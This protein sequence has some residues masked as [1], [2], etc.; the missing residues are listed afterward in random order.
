MKEKYLFLLMFCSLTMIAQ[1]R[2]GYSNNL[3]KI[4]FEVSQKMIAVE[5]N[6]LQKMKS[7]EKIIIKGRNFKII[8]S[9]ETEYASKISEIRKGGIKTE[10][11]LIYSNGAKQICRGEIIIK[12][13]SADQLSRILK[14]IEYSATKNEYVKN[15]YKV[16]IKNYDTFKIF[17]LVSSLANDERIDFVEPNFISLESFQTIDPLYA[18]QWSISNNG[19]LGGTIDADMDVEEA[20]AYSNGDGVKVAVLDIGVDLTHPDLQANLLPGF[21]A[22]YNAAGGG[23]VYNGQISAHGTACAG[24]IGAVSNNIGTVGVAYNSKIIPVR[25]S[26]A[27]NIDADDAALGINWASTFGEADILSCS[28][29]LSSPSN[30]LTN[31]INYAVSN[32]RN[33]KGC[34]V[35]FATGNGNGEV[36]YP[37]SLPNV[38]AVGATSQCDQRKSPA[39]CDG[40]NNWGSNYGTNLDIVAPGVKIATTDIQGYFGFDT[41]GDYMSTFNGTSSACPNAAGVMALILSL[42]PNLTSAQA[43]Q[44][45]ESSTDKITSYS[46]T[47]NVSGQLNGTWNNEVGYG[48]INALKAMKVLSPYELYGGN[49]VCN[50]P[51]QT[52]VG[53]TP[54]PPAGSTITWTTSSNLIVSSTLPPSTSNTPQ[55]LVQGNLAQGVYQ[56]GTVKA[57]VNGISTPIRTVNVGQKPFNFSPQKSTAYTEHCDPTHHYVA[58]DVINSDTSVNY[59]YTFGNFMTGIVNPGVTYTQLTPT[60]FLFKIPL[61]KIPSGPNPVFGFSISTTGA[62]STIPSTNYGLIVVLKPCNSQFALAKLETETSSKS[63]NVYT[64]Y[65]NPAI[66]ILNISLSDENLILLKTAKISAILYDMNGQPKTH[67]SVINNS[68][69]LDVSKLEKGIYILKIDVNGNIEDHQVVIK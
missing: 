38:I 10:P 12:T 8:E 37:A 24:I 42:N 59:T 54:T 5:E 63:A 22:V 15:Q 4:D 6:T 14:G 47:A 57:V 39:S 1:K 35:L 36:S 18:S 19:Y 68:A 52:F 58:I 69:S 31:A 7:T 23:Y 16:K 50:A 48:R 43:R 34:I 3:G 32:G 25:I 17:E 41:N 49:N 28:W 64:V 30:N 45:L 21:D 9:K 2:A 26:E 62:C 61:N 60:R 66:S 56:T 67:V 33:G 51:S 27:G 46:Y 29:G 44:I 13:K 65:P 55:I 53:I 20:W 11:V 40:E